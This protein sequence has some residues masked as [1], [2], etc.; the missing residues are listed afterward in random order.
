MQTADEQTFRPPLGSVMWGIVLSAVIP[1]VL[2][3]LSKHYLSSSEF[4]AL[5]IATTFPVAKSVF[6]LVRR[7]RVDAI[8]IVVLLGIATYG[9]ALVPGGSARL[10][11]VRE[12]FFTD[13]FF[14]SADYQ[15][16]GN[17]FR[18]R[19]DCTNHFDLQCVPGGGP[20][21]LADM[22]RYAYHRHYDLGIQRWTPGPAACHGPAQSSPQPGGV[23]ILPLI[24]PKPV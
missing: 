20:D 6:D 24:C 1:V 7:G 15:H 21:S 13:A 23:L 9:V 16:L 5:A 18:G 8:S 2:Y 3:R 4:T 17:C 22:D 14:P 10:L 12:S 11:L 19:T